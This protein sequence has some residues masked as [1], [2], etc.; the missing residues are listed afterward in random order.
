MTKKIIT[1]GKTA[2]SDTRFL[3][4]VNKEDKDL[5]ILHREFPR[6]L[7]YVENKIPVNFVV[8]DFFEPKEKEQEGINILTSEDFKKDLMDYFVSQSFNM[9]DFN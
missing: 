7:I 6:S 8:F 9:E 2:V 5:Y 1:N 4:A 3:L